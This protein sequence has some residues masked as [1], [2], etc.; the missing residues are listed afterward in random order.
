VVEK[1]VPEYRLTLQTGQTGEEMVVMDRDPAKVGMPQRRDLAGLGMG[2]V[3]SGDEHGGSS[4]P[5][6]ADHPP[7]DTADHPPEH[8]GSPADPQAK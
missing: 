3:R 7:P 8:G 4:A 1:G 5:D 2:A 6:T